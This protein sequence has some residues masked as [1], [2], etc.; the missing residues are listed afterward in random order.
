MKHFGKWLLLILL[1]PLKN[2]GQTV[3]YSQY[4]NTAIRVEGW[5]RIKW[6]IIV[7]GY[8]FEI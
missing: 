6:S 2:T 4:L 3:S 5:A 8:Y 1:K 7:K